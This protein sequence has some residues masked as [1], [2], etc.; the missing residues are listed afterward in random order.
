MAIRLL[1]KEKAVSDQDVKTLRNTVGAIIEQVRKKGDAALREYAKKF[2]GY[3]SPDVRVSPEEAGRAGDL[4]PPEV[5]EELDFA[6]KQVEAFAGAQ[7]SCICL[8]YTS[9]SPRD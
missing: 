5:R 3:E 8:L 6:M 7:K 9:P 1:K 4:L 2:D